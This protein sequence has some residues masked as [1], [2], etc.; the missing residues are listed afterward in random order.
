M[1]PAAQ[2]HG[3][4]QRVRLIMAR[5][6]RMEGSSGLGGAAPFAGWWLFDI[7]DRSVGIEIQE[8]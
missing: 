2:R 1:E 4:Q 8:R 3:I 7:A 6:A 5:E